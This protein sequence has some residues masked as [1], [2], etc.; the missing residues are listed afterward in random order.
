MKHIKTLNTQTLNHTVKKGGCGECRHHASQHVRH[1]YCWKPD[2]RAEE[3][4]KI[5]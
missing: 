2:L 3:I 1:L 4:I 5:S